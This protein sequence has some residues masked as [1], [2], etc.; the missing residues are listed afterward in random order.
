MSTRKEDRKMIAALLREREGYKRRGEK[1]RV[2]QVDEQLEHYGYEGD[3][4]QSRGPAGRSAPSG[5]TADASSDGKE[6]AAKT[7]AKKAAA[8]PA[9]AATTK[10]ADKA[11][12]DTGGK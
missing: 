5:Q 11:E 6:A 8:A 9:R 7:P 12:G 10:P 4:D 3:A 2:R 1:D